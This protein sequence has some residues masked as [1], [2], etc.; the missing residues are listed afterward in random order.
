MADQELSTARF[1]VRIRGKHGRPLN[2]TVVGRGRI[3]MS[4][5]ASVVESSEDSRWPS[6]FNEIAHD[7]V[8]EVLDRIPFNLFPDVLFLFCLQRK[9]NKDLLELFVDVVDAK[10]FERVVLQLL[11][12]S[13]LC[14][15]FS[16]ENT[17]KISKPKISYKCPSKQLG[18][19]HRYSLTRIPIT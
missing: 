3:G 8:I 12:I 5:S 4:G 7:L 10:L 13:E 16:T 14:C 1:K 19:S 9:L 11:S 17:S 15:C 6:F 2:E 18:D